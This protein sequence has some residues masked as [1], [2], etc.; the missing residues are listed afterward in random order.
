M[1][2][3]H[4]EDFM[5]YVRARD[6]NQPEFLQAVQEVM[7][8]VWDFIA[9]NPRY[10]E[11]GL[12]ERLVEPER[13]IQFRVSWVDDKGETHVNRAFRI[14]HNS[15]IGPFKGACVSIPRSI[16][17]SSSFLLLSKPSRMR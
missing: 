8:S 2:Y 10:A 15:A 3:K 11:A 16:Y 5:A 9:A 13:A 14:Q 7:G 12:L 4:L 6:P 1:K 17:R